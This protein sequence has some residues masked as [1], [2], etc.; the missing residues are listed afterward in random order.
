MD[1]GGIESALANLLNNI[2]YDKYDVTLVLEHK[3]GVFLDKINSRVHV[4]EYRISNCRFV[5]FRKIYNFSK[6]FFWTLI[7]KNKYDFSCC[8]ATYSL[9]GS[10]L[11]KIASSNSSIYIHGDYAN[12][13]DESE[14]LDFFRKRE[15]DKFNNVI[16]VSNESKNNLLKYFPSIFDKA[17]VINNFID[18]KKILSLSN[19]N[20]N[21]QKKHDILFVFVGRLE[22]DSKRISRMLKLV[23]ALKSKYSLELWIVGDGPDKKDYEKYIFVHKLEDNVKLLGA[24]KN[25]YPYMK[26]ADYILLSSQYEGFP[27]IYLESIA[28]NKKIITTIDVTD[29]FISIPG[30]VGYVVSKNVD[31]F[32]S[33]IDNILNNDNLEYKKID[34]ENLSNKKMKLLERIFDGE[35]NEKI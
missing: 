12:M 19:E 3:M 17:V 33:D 16:F 20:I 2:N 10:K 13:Y 26:K 34:F 24:K 22:E 5:L 8:Y 18:S 27:V 1:Y 4:K 25:P 7:N 9:M 14:L 28:L 32:I 30:K 11:S 15:I 31:E 35:K 6:R 21:I 23:D 29:D